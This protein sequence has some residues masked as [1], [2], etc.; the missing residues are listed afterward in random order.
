[1]NKSTEWKTDYIWV[2]H[3]QLVLHRNQ[4]PRNDGQASQDPLHWHPRPRVRSNKPEL[5]CYSKVAV[6]EAVI[7]VTQLGS[8]SEMCV[9]KRERALMSVSTLSLCSGSPVS[10]SVWTDCSTVST[11]THGTK[12]LSSAVFSL[13]LLLYFLFPLLLWLCQ[14]AETNCSSFLSYDHVLQKCDTDVHLCSRCGCHKTR[15]KQKL[16]LAGNLLAALINWQ[17]VSDL[18]CWWQIV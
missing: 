17:S 1:M 9:R 4:I 15:N 3:E 13:Q 14:R 10:L 2:G 7:R 12:K 11:R 18:H 5:L 8:P 16:E 6:L